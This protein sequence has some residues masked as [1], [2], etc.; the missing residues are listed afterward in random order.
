MKASVEAWLWGN[1][2]E[3][4]MSR[5]I[6][7]GW[8]DGQCWAHGFGHALLCGEMCAG[9]GGTLWSAW[10]ELDLPSLSARTSEGGCKERGWGASQRYE[11]RVFGGGE[12]ARK[13]W[14]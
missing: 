12:G 3:E 2:K 10:W 11:G 1:K 13:S 5:A 14:S 4:K 8:S 6:L 7:G 9:F